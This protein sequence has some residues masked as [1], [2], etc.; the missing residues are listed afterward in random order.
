MKREERSIKIQEMTGLSGGK[1]FVHHEKWFT[2]T[3]KL[4]DLLK[5]YI[6]CRIMLTG[7]TINTIYRVGI[8]KIFGYFDFGLT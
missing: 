4:V 3:G 1:I 8:W 6:F 2:I 7:V 5:G